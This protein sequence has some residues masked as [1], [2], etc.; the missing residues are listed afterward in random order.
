MPEPPNQVDILLIG[1]GHANLMALS[2][3]ARRG[4]PTISVTVVSPSLFAFLFPRH[5]GLMAGCYT[6]KES[7]VNVAEYCKWAG[8]RF[9]Q[10]EVVQV[11]PERNAVVLAN[12]TELTYD[13]LSI[14]T[15][16][17][18]IGDLVPP[19]AAAGVTSRVL[20]IRPFDAFQA[21]LTQYLDGIRTGEVRLT[22]DDQGQV[23]RV[24]V[25]GEGAAA[26]EAAL[27]I[28][29]RTRAVEG[30]VLDL[31]TSIRL[32]GSAAKPLS[33]TPIA[34]RVAKELARGG[35]TYMESAVLESVAQATNFTPAHILLDDQSTIAFDV[36]I[37]TLPARGCVS[38]G[39]GVLP[40]GPDSC[41]MTDESLMVSGAENIF[42]VGSCGTAHNR[43]GVP[44]PHERKRSDVSM[45]QGDH[46]G[47]V[48]L[49]KAASLASGRGL[50]RI[51]TFSCPSTPIAIPSFI[52]KRPRVITKYSSMT[53]RLPKGAASRKVW[54]ERRTFEER[55]FGAFDI[56]K[57][58]RRPERLAPWDHSLAA[59]MSPPPVSQAAPMRPAPL[60]APLSS[61]LLG[62]RPS[63]M[64]PVPG[65]S[66]A[67]TSL[68][69]MMPR[70][71]A[72]S[73]PIPNRP[74]PPTPSRPPPPRPG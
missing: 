56:Y 10:G 26:V 35:I 38:E 16:S 22:R 27:A 62:S 28:R 2:V 63:P 43:R 73:P 59:A 4:N 70:P 55:L 64:P 11:K 65:R 52:R 67:P 49:K 24:V 33:N 50:G 15:G 53:A 29:A 12:G 57:L 48:I 36:A 37:L 31:R 68:G 44:V 5:A 71:S 21:E 18:S 40:V 47:A 9:I 13:V 58:G 8:A 66:P 39:W 51:P 72:L 3:L 20:S 30:D 74:P 7:T 45:A 61:P 14:G 25:V 41:L 6:A 32:L 1:A 69:M 34:D 46:L 17:R 54:N 42:A 19:K 60:S 23:L